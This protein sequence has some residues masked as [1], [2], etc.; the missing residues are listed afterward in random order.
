MRRTHASFGRATSC[1]SAGRTSDDDARLWPD[2][3][4]NNEWFVVHPDGKRIA[5]V[6]FATSPRDPLMLL[7]SAALMLAAAV[8]ASLV[9]ACRAARVSPL[10]AMRD[11]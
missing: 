5:P 3:Y 9:P 8:A 2:E 4:G 7:G 10:E 6:L 11:D 1:P